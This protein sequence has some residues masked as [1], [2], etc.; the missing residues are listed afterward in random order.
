MSWAPHLV[1]DTEQ[2]QHQTGPNKNDCL[3][4][5]VSDYGHIVLNVWI[6]IEELMPS[7]ENEHSGIQEDEDGN[8]EGNA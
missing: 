3:L 5:V 8:A 2:N 4:T 6:A 7:A 1:Q